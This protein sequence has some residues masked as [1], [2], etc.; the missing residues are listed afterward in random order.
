M[1][2]LSLFRAFHNDFEVWCMDAMKNSYETLILK[3]YEKII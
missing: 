2:I 1:L 3:Y